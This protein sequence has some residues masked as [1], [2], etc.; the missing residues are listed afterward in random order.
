MLDS[1]F[2]DLK[3]PL[4]HNKSSIISYSAF[5]GCIAKQFICYEKSEKFTKEGI[6]RKSCSQQE[7]ILKYMVSYIHIL[8]S[9][10]ERSK[11]QNNDVKTFNT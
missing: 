4:N 11:D 7:F 2:S 10:W 5:Q 9:L 6:H 1:L 3:P 8:K